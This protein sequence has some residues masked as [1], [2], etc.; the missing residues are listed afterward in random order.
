MLQRFPNGG[1]VFEGQ[2]PLCSPERS[3]EQTA[4]LETELL[5]PYPTEG[6]AKA[7]KCQGLAEK[8]P[9]WSF[10]CSTQ[11]LEMHRAA[12]SKH[13][14]SFGVQRGGWGPRGRS[15]VPLQGCHRVCSPPQPFTVPLFPGLQR[16]A[17]HKP[18]EEL[19]VGAWDA[20]VGKCGQAAKNIPPA[21]FLFQRPLSVSIRLFHL[22]RG[23]LPSTPTQPL[24]SPGSQVLP[25]GR[26][27]ARIC[28][29]KRSALCRANTLGKEL[30]FR[31]VSA[32]LTPPS[33]C[34]VQ[35]VGWLHGAQ[36][37]PNT[38]PERDPQEEI[39][40]QNIWPASYIASG[41]LRG[42]SCSPVWGTTKPKPGKLKAQ[43]KS[44]ARPPPQLSQQTKSRCFPPSCPADTC[45]RCPSVCARRD[46]QQ[47][48]RF[49]QP[50]VFA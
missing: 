39:F 7:G 16:M 3:R 23:E 11:P 17:P 33:F 48:R 44:R 34:R 26:T 22:Q 41:A 13:K 1:T 4:W 10:S 35:A 40:M 27:W 12:S 50:N 6:P 25:N 32:P 18:G 31:L 9:P 46:S 42:R 38:S 43:Q 30:E 21:L 47:R 15:E 19:G 29:P 20:G 49:S 8:I 24:Q 28:A 36:P 37:N 45:C 2:P 5:C 14:H